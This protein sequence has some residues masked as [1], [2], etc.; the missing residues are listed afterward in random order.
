MKINGVSLTAA[1]RPVA[2]PA[3]RSGTRRSASTSTSAASSTLTCPNRRL[4]DTGADRNS[5]RATAAGAQPRT[6]DRRAT[7][8]A[9]RATTTTVAAAHTHASTPNGSQVSGR[10][11]R[12]AIGG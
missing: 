1:A 11:S 9:T 12:P 7:A 8:T 3:Q 5:A 2:T 4:L 10:M 6:S